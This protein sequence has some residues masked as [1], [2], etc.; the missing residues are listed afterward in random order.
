MPP[1]YIF[2][3]EN[4]SKVHG[5]KEVQHP[6]ATSGHRWKRDAVNDDKWTRNGRHALRAYFT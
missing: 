3:I 6:L 5:K 1:Q 2:T 4:V